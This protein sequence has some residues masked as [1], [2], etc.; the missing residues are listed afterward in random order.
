MNDLLRRVWALIAMVPVAVGALLSCEPLD[1]QA[2]NGIAFEVAGSRAAWTLPE[3]NPGQVTV[4]PGAHHLAVVSE[5]PWELVLASRLIQPESLA[6]VQSAVYLGVNP[7]GNGGQ[8]GTEWVRLSGQTSFVSRQGGPTGSDGEMISLDLQIRPSW[9]DP[10]G[11]PIMAEVTATLAA[12]D[13]AVSAYAHPSQ[14]SLETKAPI[15]FWYRIPESGRIRSGDTV[16]LDIWKEDVALVDRRHFPVGSGEWQQIVW[17]GPPD[18]NLAPGAYRFRIVDADERLLGSG[19]FHVVEAGADATGIGLLSAGQ[20]AGG[21]GPNAGGAPTAGTATVTE[22]DGLP[23][24]VQPVPDIRI[25]ATGDPVPPG[26]PAGWTIS[27]MN[28]E[29]F[30]LVELQAEIC[31]PDGWRFLTADVPWIDETVSAG[32]SG[33]CRTLLLGTLLGRR[34]KKIR[35]DLVYWPEDFAGR[36][37]LRID[38]SIKVTGALQPGGDRVLLRE[39]RIPL[40]PAEDRLLTPPIVLHG[41]VFVDVN[42][43]GAYETDEP[44]APGARIV[45]DGRELA[46]ANR[47]GE[48]RVTLTKAPRLVWALSDRGKSRPISVVYEEL[49]AADGRLD[50]PLVPQAPEAKRA[51][52]EAAGVEGAERT[53]RAERTNSTDGAGYVL[54]LAQ[55]AVDATRAESG[56]SVR[57]GISGPAGSLTLEVSGGAEATGWTGWTDDAKWTSWAGGTNAT[58]GTDVTD[59]SAGQGLE[60]RLD[61]MRLS[62]QARDGAIDLQFAFESGLMREVKMGLLRPTKPAEKAYHVKLDIDPRRM[63]QVAAGSGGPGSGSGGST[64]GTRPGTGAVVGSLT[65][66]Y[67]PTY[68]P[69]S[70]HDLWWANRLAVT[71]EWGYAEGDVWSCLIHEAKATYTAERG[72]ITAGFTRATHERVDRTGY[73]EEEARELS[74]EADGALQWSYQRWPVRFEATAGIP[75][76]LTPSCG[77]SPFDGWR[78]RAILAAPTGFNVQAVEWSGMSWPMPR[79]DVDEPS[80][81]GK[82]YELGLSFRPIYWREERIDVSTALQWESRGGVVSSAGGG[83]GGAGDGAGSGVDGGGD[84]GETTRFLRLAARLRSRVGGVHDV[85]LEVGALPLASTSNPNHLSRGDRR[86]ALSWR[87][88]RGQTRPWMKAEFYSKGEGMATSLEGGYQVARNVSLPW[89]AEPVDTT[90]R[91]SRAVDSD[92]VSDKVRLDLDLGST[93]ALWEW[94]GTAPLSAGDT[95]VVQSFVSTAPF[96]AYEKT[97]RKLQ[98]EGVLGAGAVDWALSWKHEAE[99]DEFEWQAMVTLGGYVRTSGRWEAGLGRSASYQSGQLSEAVTSAFRF[100]GRRGPWGVHVELVHKVGAYDVT[101]RHAAYDVIVR[102]FVGEAWSGLIQVGRRFAEG[103]SSGWRYRAG[104]E[105][106]I[107]GDRDDL[108]DRAAQAD[109]PVTEGPAAEPAATA[110]GFSVVWE[111]MDGPEPGPRGPRLEASLTFPYLW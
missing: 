25:V 63:G 15:S 93:K 16:R 81:G 61:D 48:Y 105:R 20:P 23:P 76:K 80:P 100:G 101:L 75:R 89:L 55:T 7:H 66:G 9:D 35:V 47:R 26:E 42:G 29:L 19:I 107:G 82:A 44:A 97:S 60:R 87:V 62:G 77:V 6:P 37:P 36:T 111:V 73:K 27:L 4:I 52:E 31:L 17:T 103:S 45:V 74:V 34:E 70:G 92:D 109:F 50:V 90:L 98:V 39:A 65:G 53:G 49:W 21:T 13:A 59:S 8:N 72:R 10:P 14:L 28:P 79:S 24:F 54:V 40:T 108:A 95:S 104:V 5:G 41:R 56:A 58:N 11:V 91:A 68:V 110:F 32:A 67:G 106:W 86:L 69:G 96:G 88:V 22:T 38:M 3:L 71:N 99:V 46:T 57:A 43:T 64:D 94:S 102:R 2:S 18:G 78:W 1:V 12:G 51:F 83:G 33:T 84:D 30:S 85:G